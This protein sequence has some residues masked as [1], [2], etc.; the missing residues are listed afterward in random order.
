[1]SMSMMTAAVLTAYHQP[2]TVKDVPLP[3]PGRGEVQLKVLASGLC[4]TDIHI[5]EG[6]INTVAPPRIPGHEIAGQVTAI[7]PQVSG[8]TVGESFVVRIDVVCGACRFCQSGRANLCLNHVRIGFERDGGHAQYVVVPAQNLAPVP[9]SV[10]LAQAAVVP[11]AVACMLHALVDQAHVHP[12]QTVV[13]I[14]LGGLGY[15]GLQIARHF[16]ASVIGTSRQ[17]AKRDLALRMGAQG[18]CNSS[19]Q[20]VRACAR[21]LWGEETA[22]VV[23]DIVGTPETLALSLNVA[24]RGGRAVVVGYEVHQAPFNVYDVM[25]NE[26]EIV[27]A[28]GSTMENLREALKLVADGTVVPMVTNTYPL[29]DINRALHDLETG[30][31]TGRA[32]IT[33]WSE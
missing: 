27:G 3:E 22:D 11:D 4:M 16:G 31:I 25:L 7:G 24:R 10:P 13:L 26:K 14:G 1:M 20:D 19:E 9:Q 12:G 30:K 29:P 17:Q 8:V 15:Q 5:R 6:K 28:R 32:V 33:P 18:A 21:E 2:L 23:V